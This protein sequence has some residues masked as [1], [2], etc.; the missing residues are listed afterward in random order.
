MRGRFWDSQFRITRAM[1]LGKSVMNTKGVALSTLLV[2]SAVSACLRGDG[3][4][5]VELNIPAPILACVSGD[6]VPYEVVFAHESCDKP[7][8]TVVVKIWPVGRERLVK[9]ANEVAWLASCSRVD[10][11]GRHG[12]RKFLKN[13]SVD[14]LRAFYAEPPNRNSEGSSS[15]IY[16]YDENNLLI[17]WVDYK[18][19]SKELFLQPIYEHEG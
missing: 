2:S 11:C 1:S 13:L 5:V 14:N 3:D 9:Q 18:T 15:A 17:Y 10:V 8:K 7:F 16:N 12:D 6:T 4:A 19:E